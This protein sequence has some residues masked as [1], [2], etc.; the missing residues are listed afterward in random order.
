M[1]FNEIDYKNLLGVIAFAFQ[2]GMVQS[3]DDAKVLLTLQHK[4]TAALS[5]EDLPLPEVTEDVD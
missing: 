4:L 2:N 5:E 3:A 1:M